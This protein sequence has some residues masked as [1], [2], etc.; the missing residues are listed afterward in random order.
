MKN[1]LKKNIYFIAGQ[2]FIWVVPLV[3]LVILACESK[4]IKTSISLWVAIA[5]IIYLFLFFAVFKTRIG[6]AKER[7]L[8]TDKYV[9]KWVYLVNWLTC[10]LPIVVIFLLLEK[11]KETINNSTHEI[12]IFLGILVVCI[13]IGYICLVQDSK[14][15]Q[16][17]EIENN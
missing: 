11:V 14:N 8:I 17:K 12:E 4:S 2:F 16:N 9:H 1:W 5:L 6:K 3:L 10:M 15:K 13:S 7:Q